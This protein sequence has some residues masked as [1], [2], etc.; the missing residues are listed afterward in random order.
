MMRVQSMQCRQQAGDSRFTRRLQCRLSKQSVMCNVV[1]TLEWHTDGTL[2]GTQ[3]LQCRFLGIDW[4]VATTSVQLLLVRDSPLYQCTTLHTV[5]VT[6]REMF[7]SGPSNK[8][9]N[10]KYKVQSPIK[11][12][13]QIQT[14]KKETEREMF[15]SGLSYKYQNTT[16]SLVS[17]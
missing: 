16:E 5:C 2:K 17:K 1:Q 14:H 4:H 12:Q 11:R 9:Q 3:R 15:R 6:D 13:I 7:R 8:F 10:V